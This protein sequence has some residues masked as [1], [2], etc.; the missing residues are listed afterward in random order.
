MGT[1]ECPAC[2]QGHPGGDARPGDKCSNCLGSGSISAKCD[3]CDGSGQ[4]PD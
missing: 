4:V 2:D 3:N 1:S